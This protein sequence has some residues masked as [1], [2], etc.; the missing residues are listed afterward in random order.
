MTLEIELKQNTT[1]PEQNMTQ[2][3]LNEFRNIQTNTYIEQDIRE[4]EAL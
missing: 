3:E 2:E 4:F 1:N